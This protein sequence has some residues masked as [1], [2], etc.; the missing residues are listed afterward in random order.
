MLKKLKIVSLSA[1]AVIMIVGCNKSS[2]PVAEQPDPV[3]EQPAAL[4]KV[5]QSLKSFFKTRSSDADVK[6][7]SNIA[8][9]A[10]N[11]RAVESDEALIRNCQNG[12][13]ISALNDFNQTLVMQNPQAFS[14]N[15]TN[16]FTDCIEDGTTTKGT[17]KFNIEN[18]ASKI[19][20]TATFLTDLVMQ[21]SEGNTTIKKDS[22][23]TSEDISDGVS[24][25]TTSMQAVSAAHSYKSE[26]LKSHEKENQDGST[27]S[28]D[29]S[30]K[31]TIDGLTLT[32]DETYD[33]SQTPMTTDKDDNLQKGGK[34]RYTD[35]QNH[36]IMIEAIEVNKLKISVDE[37]GDGQVDS[38]E[39]I[40]Y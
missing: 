21:E 25:E 40:D 7:N 38:E 4:P 34:A 9:A 18:N 8:K 1:I 39:V 2:D 22:F 29:I 33:A 3:V 31:Q 17:L 13:T 26:N 19:I 10:N 16:T 32:V 15:V 6:T 37:D 20:M 28:Y 36:T 14:F 23:F 30:G 11:I 35:D 27:I 24:I 12:G 5:S